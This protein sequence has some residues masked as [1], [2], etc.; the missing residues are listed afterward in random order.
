M[1]IVA[2][3][4]FKSSSFPQAEPGVR[5]ARIVLPPSGVRY[6]DLEPELDA[7]SDPELG[8]ELEGQNG[9]TDGRDIQHALEGP[10]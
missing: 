1:P 10:C 4:F 8:P 2:G 3:M 7:E 9:P 6:L 5:L